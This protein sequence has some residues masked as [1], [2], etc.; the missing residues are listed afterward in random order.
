MEVNYKGLFFIMFIFGTFFFILGGVLADISEVPY[1]VSE[2]GECSSQ[3]ECKNFCDETENINSC[4]N[5]ADKNDLMSKEEIEEARKILPFLEAGTTP[6]EC[7]TKEECMDYCDKRENFEV[8]IEFANDAGFIS[9][10]EYEIAKLTGGVGPGGCK[11]DECKNFC[12][13]SDNF[14]VCLDFA[15]E[16]GL[17]GKVIS[18]EDYEMAKKI[19]PLMKEG[20]MPGGCNS[21]SSCKDYCEDKT[22]FE[23]C[24]QFALKAG[25]LSEEEA[26]IVRK[27]GGVGPGGCMGK[28]ECESYCS[29]PL[30]LKECMEFSEEMGLG[31]EDEESKYP[32]EMG[33]GRGDE[34]SKYLE[35]MGP[36]GGMRPPQGFELPKG[37]SPP[38]GAKFPRNIPEHKENPKSSSY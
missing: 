17:I 4:L 18:N 2:L 12:E 3:E 36:P 31:R 19:L 23:E 30:N 14:E 37:M 25:L 35:E 20:E 11:R 13:N 24:T 26:N 5:Y 27:T 8:C 21:E 34:E 6:G 28:E 1:P 16:K 29:N 38:E 33:L 7:K 15:E 22:N 32:E 10:E 9:K